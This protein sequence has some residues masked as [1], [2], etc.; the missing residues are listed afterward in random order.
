MTEAINHFLILNVMVNV[1]LKHSLANEASPDSRR[2]YFDYYNLSVDCVSSALLLSITMGVGGG[3]WLALIT[4]V[5]PSALNSAWV[6]RIRYMW[7]CRYNIGVD[8]SVIFKSPSSQPAL[9][10]FE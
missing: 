6:R 7:K 3:F 8:L 5:S 4:Q 1:D 10:L 9:G 2:Q